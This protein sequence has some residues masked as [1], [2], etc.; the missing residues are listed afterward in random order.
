[1]SCEGQTFCPTYGSSSF[2]WRRKLLRADSDRLNCLLS[3]HRAQ[4]NKY[5]L[6]K[7]KLVIN[8]KND[9]LFWVLS[10]MFS[11][12]MHRTKLNQ[13][14]CW[15]N[16]YADCLGLSHTFDKIHLASSQPHE[17]KAITPELLT[18]GSLF[19][20]TRKRGTF[21]TWLIWAIIAFLRYLFPNTDCKKDPQEINFKSGEIHCNLNFPTCCIDIQHICNLPLDTALWTMFCAL[22]P[23]TTIPP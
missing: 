18:R 15:L 5:A 4:E 16:S 9:Q 10:T 20:E 11:G 8:I 2:S 7:Q 14:S 21:Q 6:L 22:S 1:M 23:N 17:A 19:I 12:H 3:V 13:L